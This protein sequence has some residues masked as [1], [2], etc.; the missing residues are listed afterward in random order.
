MGKVCTVVKI[1]PEEG[2]DPLLLASDIKKIKE[3][4]KSTVE[5]I[6]FG[7]KVVLASFVCEDSEGKDFE[8]II[9]AQVKGVSET[10]TEECGLI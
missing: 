8:E 9:K 7:A 3:C 5:E 1:Y 10:Q 6:A 2:V 4:T